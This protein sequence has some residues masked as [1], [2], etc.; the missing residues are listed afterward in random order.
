MRLITA[1]G[2]NSSIF[3]SGIA[4]PRGIAIE[5]SGDVVV[6]EVAGNLRRIAADGSSS[7]VFFSGLSVP[8]GVAIAA[9]DDLIVTEDGSPFRLWRI[10]PDGSTASVV[11]MNIKS[12]DVEIDND[13]NSIVLQELAGGQ[14]L[15]VTPSGAVSVVFSG[16]SAPTDLAIEPTGAFIVAE[17]GTGTLRRIV[18]DGSSSSV[19]FT[20]LAAVEGLALALNGDLLTAEFNLGQIKRIEPDG[21]SSAV[22]FTG[23]SGPDHLVVVSRVTTVSVDIKPGS[24]PNSINCNNEKESIT[25]AILTTD[26]FD[27]TTVDHTTVTF[28]DASETHVNKKTGVARRHQEDVDGDGD[29]D[30][31]LHFR[32]GDTSLTCDSTEGSLEGETFDGQAI[33]GADAVRM[34]RPRPPPGRRHA[35]WRHVAPQ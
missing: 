4:G 33:E 35:A 15:K 29:T 34:I 31:V 13:G 26:D 10:S 1:D 16:L 2:S 27:A 21:S 30:L 9:N 14:L 3:F 5:R 24:D 17:F 22:F 28:E 11:A 19:V 18:A 25:V 7:S 6:V 8:S 12:E 23:L 20:G 32:L